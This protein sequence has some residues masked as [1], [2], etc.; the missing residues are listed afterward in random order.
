MPAHP[1]S[2][3]ITHPPVLRARRIGDDYSDGLKVRR[4][5]RLEVNDVTRHSCPSHN[6]LNETGSDYFSALLNQ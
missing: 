2:I 5:H 6:G 4:R 1:G 3:V